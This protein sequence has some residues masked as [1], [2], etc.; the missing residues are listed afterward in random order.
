MHRHHIRGRRTALATTFAI[1]GLTAVPVAASALGV[2]LSTSGW[3]WTNPAP[4]GNTLT[5]IAF[6]GNTGFAYGSGGTV[7]RT[8]DGGSTWNGLAT[9]TGAQIFDVD[10]IDANTLVARVGGRQACSLRISSDGGQTFARV[11]FDGGESSCDAAVESVDFVSKSDGFVLMDDGRVLK[12][13]DGGASF[14]SATKVDGGKQIAFVDTTTGFATTATTLK[15]TPDGG[16]TWSDVGQLPAGVTSIRLRSATSLVGWGKN[17][18]STSSDGG[19]SWTSNTLGGLDPQSV[20]CRTATQCALY[21][22]NQLALTADAGATLTKATIGNDDVRTVGYASGARLVAVG[23]RGVTY[24]SDDDGATFRRT[25]SDPVAEA[26]TNIDVRGGGGPVGITDNGRIARISGDAWTL[27]PTLSTG[28]LADADFVDDK[29][30]FALGG[31][32]NLQRTQNGGATWTRLDPGTPSSS[33]FIIAFDAATQVLIGDFGAYRSGTTGVF[34]AVNAKPLKG[35]RPDG[36]DAKGSRAAIWDSRAKGGGIFVT[37]NAGK[38][39]AEVKLPK[40]TKSVGEVA[41]I[42][43]NGLLATIDGQLYRASSDAGS[44]AALPGIGAQVEGLEAAGG[45]E[46]LAVPRGSEWNDAVVLRSKDA[47][48]TFAA[49]SLAGGG[50]EIDALAA[51]GPGKAYAA[52]IG[53]EAPALFS[54][55]TGGVRGVVGTISLKRTKSSQKSSSQNAISGTLAN[56]TGTE[57]VRVAYRKRGSSS[58]TSKFVNAGANGGSFSVRAKLAKGTYDVVAQWTGDSGRAGLGSSALTLTIT[59]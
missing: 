51:D 55:A 19:V 45:K 57:I 26:I 54:T 37:K 24:L 46:F 25:S 5:G 16:Q 11:V 6:T 52:V 48:K 35:L 39:W 21:G 18:L 20:S 28:A 44:W 32:G 49:Q 13:N 59:K 14:G 7:L 4:Q 53:G 23:K 38:S 47:G 12:T 27:L 1:A 29:L 43:K 56:A 3:N 41:V 8:D 58:W 42:P 31:N 9:G 22:S 17:I 34:D 10:L 30:G 15:K 36:V 33:K 40:G 2:A 50:N